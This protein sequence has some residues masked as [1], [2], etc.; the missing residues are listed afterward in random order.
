MFFEKKSANKWTHSVQIML[1]QGGVLECQHI[2]Y[3]LAPKSSVVL[4]L[5]FRLQPLSLTAEE[6]YLLQ[7]A[8]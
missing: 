3:K 1:F 6:E 5:Y 7:T 2:Q 4:H 8:T